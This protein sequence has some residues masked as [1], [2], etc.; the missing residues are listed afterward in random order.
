MK[1]KI[2]RLQEIMQAQNIDAVAMVPGANFYHV[3]RGSFGL[4]ER[5]T[6]III[7]VDG[8]PVGIIPVL[9]MPAFSALKTGATTFEWQDNDGFQHAFNAAAKH[10]GSIRRLGVEGQRMRVFE[11]QAFK[12]AFGSIEI[13]NMQAPISSLRLC[14]TPEEISLLQKAVDIS[15][16]A[17]ED[18]IAAVKVGMTERDIA[19]MLVNRMSDHG[20]H[21]LSF[22]PIVAAAD[23]AAEPHAHVRSDYN[24]MEGDAL[25]IDF[26]AVFNRYCADIT[27]TFFVGDVSDEHRSFYEAVRGANEAGHTVTKAGAT[28]HDVDDAVQLFLENSGYGE[29][30]LTKTGH[31]LGLDVHED[32]YIMRGNHM[33]LEPGMVFTNEPG[34][35]KPGDLGVRIEDDVVVTTD[36]YQCLTSFTKELRIVG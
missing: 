10:L 17:L 1:N 29:Y 5:P 12:Q 35:Y 4:M 18:T 31:G 9:E 25:L 30:V 8:A 3:T 7:P 6:I 13:V 14:K 11:A 27:R 24:I 28:A 33:V 22:D 21:G 16:A 26:G 15:E 23:N 19:T 20:S 2:S 32:P 34:L 36:G